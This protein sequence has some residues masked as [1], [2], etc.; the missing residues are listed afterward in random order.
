M[1]KASKGQHEK[2]TMEGTYAS[3][4]MNTD[5]W[6]H[7]YQKSLGDSCFSR[8]ER[9]N[10]VAFICTWEVGQASSKS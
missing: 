7:R 6:H 4:G 2:W 10:A 9:Q 8:A 1:T 5:S 3:S